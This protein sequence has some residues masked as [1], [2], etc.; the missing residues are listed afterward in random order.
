MHPNRGSR[1]ALL[2]GHVAKDLTPTG[3]RL[4]GTV[5]FA[6]LTLLALGC[7]VQVVTSAAT[8]LDLAPLER[9]EVAC[10]PAAASTTF[11]NRYH[12]GSRVQTLTGRA[13][14]LNLSQIPDRWRQGDLL[15]LG[16][17]ADEVDPQIAPATRF[18]LLGVTAQGWL[19][20]AGPDG[21]VSL[22]EWTSLEGRLPSNAVVVLSLE[23]LQ[24]E[25]QAAQKIARWCRVLAVTLGARGARVYWQAQQ[26]H[27]PAPA[28]EEIDPTG[29][30]DI[31]AATFLFR[32]L[33]GDDPPQAARWANR[34]AAQSV[35]RTGLDSVP[36]AAEVRASGVRED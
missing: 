21:R 4:G 25:L 31:F 28:A 24:G 15:L 22:E 20:R 8:D 6:G 12:D 29:A 1:Q 19:R 33:R 35:Q 5:S 13:A 23:D 11:E 30:G 27:L 14:P 10:Q 9:L 17:I 16:P 34:L 32:L 7:R 26:E 3:P 36:T 18:D 2:I